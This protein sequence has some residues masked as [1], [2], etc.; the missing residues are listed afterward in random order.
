VST[1][2]LTPEDISIAPSDDI[3]LDIAHHGDPVLGFARVI[4][5]VHV[6]ANVFRGWGPKVLA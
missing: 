4:T 2:M 6:N 1:T 3:A 5:Q